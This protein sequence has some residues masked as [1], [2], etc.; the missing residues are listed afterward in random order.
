[1]TLDNLATIIEKTV[2]K[3][4]DLAALATKD[5]LKFLDQK[6]D[7][8]EYTMKENFRLVRGEIKMLNFASRLM[9]SERA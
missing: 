9:V 3:K 8:M 5:N 7:A 4:E 6:M 2:A 1:M